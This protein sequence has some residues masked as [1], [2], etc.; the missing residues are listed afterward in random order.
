MLTLHVQYNVSGLI[1]YDWDMGEYSAVAQILHVSPAV[2]AFF[3]FS[4]SYLVISGFIFGQNRLQLL[5]R[6]RWYD[7]WDKPH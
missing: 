2:A 4:I 1:L 3:G 5:K 6:Y 7:I